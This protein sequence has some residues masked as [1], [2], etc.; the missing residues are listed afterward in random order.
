MTPCWSTQI[1]IYLILSNNQ[2]Q[3]ELKYPRLC[4]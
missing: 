4:A 1:N 2:I 3:A